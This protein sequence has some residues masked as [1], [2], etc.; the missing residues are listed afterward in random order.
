[1]TTTPV[2]STRGHIFVVD[3]VEDNHALLCRALRRAGFDATAFDN[4]VDA[5]AAISTTPPDL[6][7]LDWMMPGLSGLEVLAA[8]RDRYNTNELPIIMCTARDESSSIRS[9][10]EAGAND[11]V[12][13]PIDMPIAIARVNAQLERR[14]ALQA[15]AEVNR[16]LEATLAARTLALMGKGAPAPR[17][18]RGD[19][20]RDA[21]EILRLA[22]WLRSP[23]ALADPVL[24]SACAD[25][26]ASVAR[27]L[28]AH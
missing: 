3:D 27:R 8:V 28:V 22:D 20:T 11:Y 6:L 12:Q 26:L 23:Q 10:L 9:A 1:M 16:D 4:G 25:S 18:V 19:I 7:M 24:V 13:K 15:L 21:D 14:A 5:I 17:D 2:A